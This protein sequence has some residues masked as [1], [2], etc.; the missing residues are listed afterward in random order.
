MGLHYG[1]IPVVSD[2]GILNDTVI[3]IFD[4]I[5]E[6]NGFKTKQSLLYEDENTNV[7]VNCLEKALNIYNN[8][9]SSWNIIIKNG[10]SVNDNDNFSKYE[11]YNQ[12]Y[13]DI[14]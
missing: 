12:I 11:Q 5:A 9:P 1:C 7:Y 10:F 14:L 3:D 2:S 8:N 13:Q 4:N 6:G